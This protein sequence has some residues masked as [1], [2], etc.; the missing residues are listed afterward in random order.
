V[1][2]VL[3]AALGACGSTAYQPGV[4]GTANT[5]GQTGQEGLSASGPAVS[6]GATAATGDESA[7]TGGLP[8]EE[9]GGQS[10]GGTGS[11]APPSGSAPGSA[12]SP[13]GGSAAVAAGAP[14]SN[15]PGVTASTINFGL[16]YVNETAQDASIGAS[17][18]PGD[19]RAEEQAVIDYVNAHGG[20]AHRKI[21]PIWFLASAN[22]D[23]NTTVQQACA[24]WTQD[25][26]AFIIGLGGAQM[27]QCTAKA[28]AIELIGGAITAE[29]TAA[30][31][32]FPADIN[33]T[34]T[35]TDRA[36]RYT[37]EGL[38]GQGYFSPGAKVGVV[39]WD[40]N[41]YHYS[42]T[43][44]AIPA[45]AAVGIHDPPVEY[46][47]VP[48][49]YGDLG[50]TSA[51][52]GSAVLRF[53]Q[54]G[55]D[56]VILFD[57]P[58]GINASGILVLEWMTVSQVDGYHPRYGLNSTSGFSS[59]ASSYPAQQMVGSVGVSW[60]P[61]ADTNT[62]QYGL[63]HLSPTGK[64]CTQIED[65]AGQHATSNTQ[66][67]V[68][69]VFCDKY[70]FLQQA[71]AKVTGPLNQQ[72]ALAAIDAIGSGYPALSTFGIDIA[73]TRHDGADKVA[74]MAF[75]ASCTCYEYSSTPYAP[76]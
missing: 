6:S 66:V 16:E 67:W 58:A 12:S 71:L 2:S 70:F 65:K 5:G 40:A 64:L 36:M 34:G 44:A 52:V 11:S 38:A 33:L 9:L 55:V 41:D 59:L 48:N 4:G 46:V 20:I 74:N 26:H 63:S 17:Y 62:A 30:N 19:L 29:T 13:I 61:W 73:A 32:Q 75:V 39:T 76:G 56:H 1:A 3:V 27:D 35:T 31:A 7:G 14:G 57:G 18:N 72:T 42:V 54:L 51:A 37:V 10:N 15:G 21:N 25:H 43:N 50:A 68:Q 45:L 8:G 24:D 28:G 22:Q 60:L 49:S 23:V 47:A 53:H 69:M